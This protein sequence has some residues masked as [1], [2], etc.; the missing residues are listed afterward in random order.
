[1]MADMAAGAAAD[2]LEKPEPASG[3][4][5]KRSRDGDFHGAGNG[6]RRSWPPS[7]SGSFRQHTGGSW[8]WD[9][10][11]AVTDTVWISVF[12]LIVFLSFFLLWN[13]IPAQWTPVR[14]TVINNPFFSSFFSFSFPHKLTFSVH[15]NLSKSAPQ[16][17]NAYSVFF[18]LLFCYQ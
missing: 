10:I 11:L 12:F 13:D 5:Q 9:A 17:L 6:E 7:S 18:S 2:L 14:G 1:M 15:F 8:K 4:G 3:R 16:I